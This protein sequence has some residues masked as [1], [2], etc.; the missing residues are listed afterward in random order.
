MAL[1]ELS[2]VQSLHIRVGALPPQISRTTGG[3][4]YHAALLKFSTLNS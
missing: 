2:I 3:D 4:A 1:V